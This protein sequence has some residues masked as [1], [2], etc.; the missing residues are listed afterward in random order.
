MTPTLRTTL[1]VAVV[2]SSLAAPAAFAVR[3]QHQMR[4]FRVV[5]EGVL[6]RSGQMTVDGLRRAAHDYGIRTIVTLRDSADPEL[7]TLDRDEDD[8][9]AREEILHLRL[10]PRAWENWADPAAPAPV[11][12]NVRQFLAVMR[13][14]KNYPALVHCFAGVHRTGAYVAVY[15]MEH[16]R[17]PNA[18]ALDEM[19]ACGYTTLD[20]NWDILGYLERYR[21]SWARGEGGRGPAE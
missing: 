11:E 20:D 10:P 18:R 21:P 17:W 1:G 6:Y 13:D 3:Q 15:R 2:L 19:R 7:S 4:N 16:E 9:C 12:E 5:R 8:F 14:E